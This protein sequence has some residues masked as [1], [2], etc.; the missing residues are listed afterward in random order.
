MCASRRRSGKGESGL[1]PSPNHERRN[2]Q[3]IQELAR[4]GPEKVALHLPVAY[5]SATVHLAKGIVLAILNLTFAT[6]EKPKF[7]KGTNPSFSPPYLIL[8]FET[9]NSLSHFRWI[10]A[11][12]IA[13]SCFS[14]PGRC[15]C[16]VIW[17]LT[18]SHRQPKRLVKMTTNKEF[19]PPNATILTT[20]CKQ[21][22]RP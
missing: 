5:R 4:G 3:G 8:R 19:T 9:R 20:R 18:A 22:C 17:K 21:L 13:L 16:G 14:V 6:E 2:W 10:M 1:I 12:S 15:Y 11:C 7:A